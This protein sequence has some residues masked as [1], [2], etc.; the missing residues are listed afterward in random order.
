MKLD[1]K[2][3]LSEDAMAQ[4]VLH[5]FSLP[6][7]PFKKLDLDE[8]SQVLSKSVSLMSEKMLKKSGNK[9]IKVALSSKGDFNK[10]K[11]YEDFMTI[12][13]FIKN[14]K[15][16]GLDANLVSNFKVIENS[17]KLLEKEKDNFKKCFS[18]GNDVGQLIYATVV[19]SVQL[20]I[21][22]IFFLG[23]NL[24]ENGKLVGIKNRVKNKSNPEIATLENILNMSKS[25][26]LRQIFKIERSI[27][28]EDFSLKDLFEKAKK[29]GD[30]LY[31]TNS[32]DIF[33]K[34]VEKLTGNKFGIAIAVIA[35][36]SLSLWALQSSY[37]YLIKFRTWFSDYLR[38][39]AQIIENSKDNNTEKVRE[40]QGKM[41]ERLNKIADKIDIEDSVSESQSKSEN[42]KVNQDIGNELETDFNISF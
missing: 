4:K 23:F 37:Y 18:N 20:G 21:S 7:R 34:G 8:Q 36:A 41:S 27:L 11:G 33:A 5:E 31:K 16:K 10:V 40:R 22:K 6:F 9:N 39:A 28:N 14:N 1:R 38:D 13:N 25:G 42:Q 32:K 15:N 3:L 24:D 26:N 19:S 17:V 29:T 2:N 35:A 30:Y 12:F